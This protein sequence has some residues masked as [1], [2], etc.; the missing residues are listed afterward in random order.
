MTKKNYVYLLIVVGFIVFFNSLFNGFVWDDEEQVLNN[1]LVHSIANLPSFF[2]GSTF[3]TGGSGEL[4][5]MYYKPI[6]S[7]A[8]ALIYTIFGANAFFFH[9]FQ[10][11]IHIINSIFVFLFLRYFFA[12]KISFLLALIFLVHPINIETAVYIS[13]LQDTLYFFFGMLAL[14]YTRGK[15]WKITQIIAIQ[16]FLLLS[17]LSKETGFLFIP[18]IF[19]FCYLFERKNLIAFFVLGILTTA[20]YSFLRFIVSGIGFISTGPS[21]IMM[22]GIY[23]RITNIPEIVFYYIRTFLFPKDLAIAQHWIIPEINLDKFYLPLILIIIFFSF[24]IFF[25]AIYKQ[26]EK[27]SKP[28]ILFFAWIILGLGLHLQMFPLDMT[29]ADRWFYF[30]MVGFLGVMAI[31]I[32]QVKVNYRYLKIIL[33]GILIAIFIIFSIRTIIRNSNWKNGL[34]LYSHDI[35]ISRNAFDLENN[36]G[37]ELYRAGRLDEAM[38]H[39]EASTKL[40]PNWWTNWN[41]LGAI[42]EQK[43]DLERAKNYYQK[44]VNNG[45]YYLAY[46]NLA[47]F[48]LHYDTPETA[49]AFAEQSLKILPN[50]STLWFVLAISEYRLKDM[51]KALIAAKNAYFLDPSQ[52][53]AYIYQRLF[54]KLP[55]DTQ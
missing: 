14:L 55:L 41:N 30:P 17:I 19:L 13:A 16:I 36:F 6:M 27:F 37:V 35:N 12:N 49:K 51:D 31:I 32:H 26:K 34:T 3:N 43:N 45:Q 42:L 52:R 39:F 18:L 10:V 38:I 46:E 23:E 54:Q 29:V 47:K 1:G 2:T 44:A 5:G 22:T 7:S 21:P 48:Y 4:A 24:I 9:F 28:F 40:A 53:N 50:N 11:T 15:N 33:T 20:I 25:G 8:F